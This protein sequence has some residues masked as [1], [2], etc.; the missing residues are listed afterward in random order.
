MI[1]KGKILLRVQDLEQGRRRITPEIAAQF[2]DL[3]EHEEGVVGTGLF[4]AL[5]DAPRQGTDIGPPVAADLGLVPDPAQGDA[6]EFL[7]HG[8]GD[9]LAKRGLAHARRPHKAQDGAMQVLF[10][11]AHRQK[12]DDPLLDLLQ[13]VMI[14]VQD[15]AGLVEIEAVAGGFLP[16]QVQNPL[17]I[18]PGNG[19][20]RRRRGDPVETGQLLVHGLACLTG[21]LGGLGLFAQV[22]SPAHS[23]VFPQLLADRLELLAQEKLALLLVNILLD[24]LLDLLAHL[25]GLELLVKLEGH[26]LEQFLGVHDLQQGLL[27]LQG[28]VE[29]GPGEIG[30]VVRIVQ[31]HDGHHQF[32]GELGDLGHLLELGAQVEDQ[33]LGLLILFM[34]HGHR[35]HP[36]PVEG[37][38]LE[39]FD[40]PDLLHRA[41]Q[42]LIDIVLSLDH[43]MNIAQAADGKKMVRRHRLS[44]GVLDRPVRNQG[45]EAIPHQGVVDE[46]LGSL[47]GDLEREA[48]AG[49]KDKALQGQ[50]GQL[51]GNA[52]FLG[53]DTGPDVS[54]V[55][56]FGLAHIFFLNSYVMGSANNDSPGDFTR[57]R[58]RR[59]F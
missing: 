31:G 21:Q 50:D 18:R 30:H 7:V 56:L 58:Y 40:H 48:H 14:V 54:G 16:R 2:V 29:L 34:D 53:I 43:L 37:L 13:A 35:L 11:L 45:H 47:M 55:V 27:R 3:V 38:G 26:L 15:P 33:G 25:Q 28:Q 44:L 4:E 41:H 17:D 6:D 22:V 59:S 19:V 42:D 9:G 8:T 10:E 20:L 57:P 5:N 36:A 12:F 49:E 39:V 32:L 23:V 46:I 51:L 24:I 1:G 52:Q